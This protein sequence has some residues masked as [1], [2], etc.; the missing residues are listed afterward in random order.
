MSGELARIA[1]ALASLGLATLL[2]AR[3]RQLRIGGLA[4]WAAGALVLALYLAPSGHH[5]AL[6]AAA[7]AGALLAVGLAFL[8]RRW[9]WLLAVLVL[10]CVPAR[11]PVHVGG[12]KANLLVP[13]YAVVAASALLLAWELVRGDARSR[14]LGPL[15]WPLAV[16]VG[17]TGL[18]LLWTGDERQGAISLLFSFLPFG[19]LAVT[20]ARLAWSR[21]WL[22]VLWVQ[23]VVMALAF[24]VIGV[25]QW[26]TRDIFW[27]P[28]VIVGNAYAPFFRV[29]S[30]FY[31]PSVYGR[32]LVLALVACLVVVVHG[33]S[34]RLAWSAAAATAAIWV[35]LLL[36]FSQSSFTALTAAGVL[37]AFS[38][39]RWRA[40]AV[41]GLVAAVV[42]A[43]GVATPR[44]RSSIA[45]HAHVGLKKATSG[46]SKLVINGAK[47]ALH[48][49]V[50]GVGIGDFKRAYAKQVG[51][52]GREPKSAASHDTPV[53]VAAETGL[54]G[55]LLL[56][57][58]VWTALTASLRRVP[59]TFAGRTS[60][61]LGLGLAAIAVHSLFY[62]AFF[63]DPTTWGLFALIALAA[64][65][66]EADA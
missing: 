50:V 42:I 63:E 22:A 13:L 41:V 30:V 32:F 51:L 66:R 10:A 45:R 16:F 23:L 20:L 40:L 53:T 61:V 48:H 28:T 36:S 17:W 52:K 37:L 49:P 1:G 43:A 58:L 57:W 21:R 60:L 11:I 2:V 47:V 25:Y 39:W 3:P 55:L 6:A 14:E 33:R 12:T 18:S 4:V 19:L 46:R 31:D 44:I 59:A 27:N 26:A 54:P 64:R 56:V 5:R 34:R 7:V 8:F 29:N 38:V 15:A 65:A 35:G 62:N 9:P 24:T